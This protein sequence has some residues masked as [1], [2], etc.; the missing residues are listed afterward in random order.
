LCRWAKRINLPVTLEVGQITDA[1]T[2]SSVAPLLQM[3]TA[4]VSDV[5]GS[6]QV[7]ELPLNAADC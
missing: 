5:V 1:I 2:V 3:G 6:R 4:E 7:V